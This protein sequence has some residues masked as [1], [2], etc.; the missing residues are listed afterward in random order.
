MFIGLC[1]INNVLLDS[2]A[3]RPRGLLYKVIYDFSVYFVTFD[4][5]LPLKVKPMSQTFQGIVSHK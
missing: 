1:I 3:V 4:L 2:G 5:G